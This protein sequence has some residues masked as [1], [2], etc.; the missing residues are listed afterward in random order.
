[1]IKGI[2][3]SHH[4]NFKDPTDILQYDFVIMKAT[5][6]CNFKDPKI[7]LYNDVLSS[8]G[9]DM[10]VRGFYHFARP[11]RLNHYGDEAANF[12]KTVAPYL[13]YS[14]ILALDVEAQALKFPDLDDWCLAWCKYVYN[15]TRVKPL[16]YCSAAEC[17]RFKKCAAFGCGLWVA[18]WSITKPT[19]KQILPWEFWAIWQYYNAALIS[20]AKTDCDY[21]NGTIEQLVK[22]G[23][24]DH[25]PEDDKATKNSGNREDI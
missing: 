1:M 11:E 15:M 22:Y 6:G 12:L 20:G 16:I 13:K 25:G 2:D 23:E 5:E 21:F 4:N 19:K 3:I 8:A 24:A 10:P 9:D 18:K 17:H 7:K 14:P